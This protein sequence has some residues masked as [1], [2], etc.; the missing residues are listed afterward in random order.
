MSSGCVRTAATAKLL[1]SVVSTAQ[2]GLS[3]VCNTNIDE[4]VCVS[5]THDN[6]CCEQ[7]LDV[8]ELSR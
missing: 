2:H 1:A 8:L 5:C 6:E 7:V 4:K 3:K